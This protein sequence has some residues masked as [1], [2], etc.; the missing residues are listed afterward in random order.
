MLLYSQVY[1]QHDVDSTFASIHKTLSAKSVEWDVRIESL[2]ELR[3]LV[4]LEILDVSSFLLSLRTL[5]MPLNESIKDLRSQVVRE[6]CVTLS[7]LA[8]QLRGDMVPLAELL[9]PN[10]ISLL[11][12]SAKVMATSASVCIR[13]M[14]KVVSV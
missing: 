14:I 9:F 6:T 4:Q 12:N 2:K 1:T 7:C 3:A 5:E 11:P 10:L 8:V 13:I